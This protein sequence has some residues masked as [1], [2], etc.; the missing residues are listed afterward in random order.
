MRL[1]AHEDIMLDILIQNGRV[2]DGTGAPWRTSDVGIQGGRIAAMGGLAG[3]EAAATTDAK[4]KVVCPGFVDAHAHSELAVLN[5]PRH[6]ARV[7]QGVTTEAVGMCGLSVAPASA[8][9]LDA[10][11]D[12]IVTVLAG[13]VEPGASFSVAELFGRWDKHIAVNLAYCVPHAT[14]RVEA[15]GMRSGPVSASEMAHMKE[16]LTQGLQDGA[17]GFSTGLTYFPSSE[18]DTRELIELAQ[19]AAE[20]GAIYATHMRNYGD[21][22]AESLEEAI[23]IGRESGAP[24]QVA[25]FRLG[26][27]TKGQAEQMLARVEQARDEGVDITI[28]CYPYLVGCTLLSYFILAADALEGDKAALLAKLRDPAQRAALRRNPMPGPDDDIYISTVGSD[29]NRELEGKTLGQLAERRG[30]DFFDAA[31]DLL[32]EEDLNVTAIGVKANEDDVRRVLKHPACMIG[33]D[34][35]PVPGQCHPR[36]YGAFSRFLD[37]YVLQGKLLPLEQAIW[38]MTGF[39]AWRYGLHDRGLLKTG[40]AADVVV[41]DPNALHDRAT[42]ENPK[43]HPEGIEHVIV[44]GE[45]VVRDGVH[46]GATPGGALRRA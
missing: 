28:D 32:I 40:L 29:A 20:H 9:T 5:N 22:F 12:Y 34:T 36:V 44:N 39:P 16:L 11:S 21:G 35:V 10:M 33:S 4:G 18:A 1:T 14:L 27:A 7:M 6:E 30:K 42:Y 19:V 25:H 46:T 8:A 38:K 24:V 2:I 13:H 17:V 3:A 26:G 31:C 41:F 23:T 15:A 45:F 37:V 43:Q